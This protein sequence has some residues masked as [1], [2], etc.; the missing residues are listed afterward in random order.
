MQFQKLFSPKFAFF[1]L[2]IV[3]WFSFFPYAFSQ[4]SYTNTVQLENC[5][6]LLPWYYKICTSYKLYTSMYS[7]FNRVFVIKAEI[8]GR[9]ICTYFEVD[10]LLKRPD[11]CKLKSLKDNLFMRDTVK[12]IKLVVTPCQF[13]IHTGISSQNSWRSLTMADLKV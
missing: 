7:L 9:I 3:A 13:H 4:L 8:L 2:Q 10:D 1:G 6:G 11:S 5:F 12:H